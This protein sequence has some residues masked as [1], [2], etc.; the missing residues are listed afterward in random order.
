MGVEI[1]VEGLTKSFGHQV[2]W[3][4]VSLTLPMRRGV[5]D[6]R[7]FGHGQVGVPQDARRA[8]QARTRV[9]PD[10]GNR[11]HRPART[12]PVRGAEA[13]RRAVPGRRAVR[14]HEPL[15][16]HR[17]PAAGAHPQAGERDQTDRAREDGHGRPDRRR[18]ETARRDIRRYAQTGGTGPGAGAR[19]GDHPL[20]RAG[21]GARPGPGGLSQ[22]ADRRPQRADRRD[23]SD[24]HPRH[25]LRAAGPGQHRSALPPRTGDV[26][27]PREA[28]D[29]RGAGGTAVPERPDARSDRHGRGEGRGPG[30]AGAGTARRS[31]RPRTARPARAD[32]APSAHRG[33]HPSAA[34]GGDRRTRGTATDACRGARK[35]ADA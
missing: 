8:A 3:Q 16:Q 28:A 12:R 13:V 27:P 17:L 33:D 5:G 19:S 21:L 1:C 32:A 11:H 20:R 7:P 23:L 34:L 15:R 35:G 2:I 24:R 25:R 26:R 31:R 29:Q 18:G 30:R 4:D 9:D 6:A 22:P 10:R 14:V